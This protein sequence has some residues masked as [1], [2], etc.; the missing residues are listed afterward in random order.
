MLSWP[1]KYKTGDKVIF[2]PIPNY[3]PFELGYYKTYEVI[4]ASSIINSNNITNFIKVKDKYITSN[5]ID[6]K[7]FITP[8]EYRK[9]KL[10]KLNKWEE[11]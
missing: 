5:W 4:Q 8:I 6:E 7:F 9:L 1:R 2:I 11:N 3:G 10:Q